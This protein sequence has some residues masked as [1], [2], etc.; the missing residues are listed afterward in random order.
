MGQDLRACD[1]LG[2][3][4]TADPGNIP[5]RFKLGVCLYKADRPADALM[6]FRDLLKYDPTNADIALNMGTTYAAMDSLDKA[7]EMWE[8]ALAIDPDNEIARENLRTAR[9]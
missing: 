8:R 9:Q 6:H 2:K 5:L 1:V 3:I 7:I 4:L